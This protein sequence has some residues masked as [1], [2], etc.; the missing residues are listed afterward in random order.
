MTF[1]IIDVNSHETRAVNSRDELLTQLEIADKRCEA[2]GLTESYLIEHLDRDG[3]SVLEN[4]KFTLPYDGV[5]DDLLGEFG[6]KRPSKSRPLTAFKDKNKG[7]PTNMTPESPSQHMA[8]SSPV[9]TAKMKRQARQNK[10]MTALV[11]LL[12]LGGLSLASLSLGQITSLKEANQNLTEQ[13][14]NLEL[15]AAEKSHVDVFSRYF[16]PNYY[17]NN[18]GSVTD[19]IANNLKETFQVSEG[20]LQ[21]VILED[22]KKENDTYTM[23]YVLVV[24][25][26]EDNR[27]NVRLSFDVKAD[28]KATYG[29]LVTSQPKSSKYPK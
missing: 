1:N 22:I 16:L 17:A 3:E 14:E 2:L 26:N 7:K 5:I 18:K 25:D 6:F 21:S 4:I 20:T 28:S 9:L 12:A 24:K 15:L 27:S 13:V 11:A 19:F 29:Y 23:T 8:A 10:L